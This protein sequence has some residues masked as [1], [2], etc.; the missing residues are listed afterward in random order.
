MCVGVSVGA[1]LDVGVAVGA[2]PATFVTALQPGMSQVL[3]ELDN[4]S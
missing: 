2:V 3:A 1:G 4:G